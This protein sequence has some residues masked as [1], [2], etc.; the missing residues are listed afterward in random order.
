MA[1]CRFGCPTGT[2]LNYLRLHGRSDRFTLR[3]G[4]AV[5]LVGLAVGLIAWA[6]L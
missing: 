5:A 6:R 1:Y 2:V 3:D 4:A